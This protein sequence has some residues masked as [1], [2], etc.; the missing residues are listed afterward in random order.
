MRNSYKGYPI[1]KSYST[2][3][4]KVLFVEL[5]EDTHPADTIAVSPEYDK[6][7]VDKVLSGVYPW[8]M[9]GVFVICK[10]YEIGAGYLGGIDTHDLDSVGANDVAR[11]AIHEARIVA[12]QLSDSLQMIA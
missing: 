7:Y 8:Y 10:G 5:P 1:I 3:N 4:F 6:E 2:R 12:D 9:L 11:D